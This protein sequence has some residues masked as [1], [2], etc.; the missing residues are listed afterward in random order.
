M[1][2]T[3]RNCV[4]LLLSLKTAINILHLLCLSVLSPICFIAET[5][6]R[7]SKKLALAED[8]QQVRYSVSD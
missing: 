4:L 2:L 8:F 5:T 6:E 3:S 7:T 1:K